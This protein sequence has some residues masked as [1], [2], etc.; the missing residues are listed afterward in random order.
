M[1][2]EVNQNTSAQSGEMMQIKIALAK[3]ITAS[4]GMTVGYLNASF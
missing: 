4:F 2:S 3:T 1:N